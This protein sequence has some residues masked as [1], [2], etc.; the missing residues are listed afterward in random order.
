VKERKDN[1]IKI[2]NIKTYKKDDDYISIKIDRSSPLGNP[3][4]MQDESKRDYVCDKYE[5]YFNNKINDN[6]IVFMKE[7]DK[8]YNLAINNDI[9][10]LCWC[11]PKR[12]HGE[13]IKRYLE[14]RR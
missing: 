10:L 14:K 4:Y 8:I 13:T 11:S 1:M 9:V 7:L 3:F 12:C 2:G 6:D 5:E